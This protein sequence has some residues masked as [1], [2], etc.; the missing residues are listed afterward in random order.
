MIVGYMKKKKLTIK[1]IIKIADK[2][3]GDGLVLRA[4]KGD[5]V[6]DTLAIFIANELQDTFDEKATNIDKLKEARRVMSVAYGE[7]GDI[8]RRFNDFVAIESSAT[9]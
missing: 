5:D 8:F 9:L 1:D 2:V 6:G 7:I 4:S 3:Y